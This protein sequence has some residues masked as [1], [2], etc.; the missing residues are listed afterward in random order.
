MLDFYD[1]SFLFHKGLLR[2]CTQ[3]VWREL[4]LVFKSIVI[5]SLGCSRKW[6]R[7]EPP[8]KGDTSFIDLIYHLPNCSLHTLFSSPPLELTKRCFMPCWAYHM[9][10]GKSWMGRHWS[11]WTGWNSAICSAFPSLTDEF[12][13]HLGTLLAAYP[14]SLHDQPTRSWFTKIR[15]RTQCHSR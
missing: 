9:V 6:G 5:D 2:S 13:A 10:R 11:S 4:S 12:N 14:P 3:A 1:L 15:Q 7:F 8:S